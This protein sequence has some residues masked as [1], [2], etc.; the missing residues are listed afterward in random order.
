MIGNVVTDSYHE[1]LKN[2]SARFD[3][4]CSRKSRS[5]LRF[6]TQYKK[7]PDFKSMTIGRG[8]ST[9]SVHTYTVHVSAQLIKGMIPV[10]DGQD[11]DAVYVHAHVYETHKFKGRSRD[12][13]RYSDC[14]S[15]RIDE[16]VERFEEKLTQLLQYMEDDFN[17][18]IEDHD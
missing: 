18:L 13:T 12:F 17:G 16:D 10:A 2:V 1:I 11:F 6:F 8:R 15:H 4:T 14:F 9:E 3:I 5:P 7:S